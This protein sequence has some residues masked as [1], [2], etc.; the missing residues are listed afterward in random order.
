[1]SESAP[2]DGGG[3]S[4]PPTHATA[5][6][7]EKVRLA[8]FRNI[9]SATLEPSSRLN[10]IW[11]DNGQGKTS[12]LEALYA[13]ATTRS[14]RTDKLAQALRTGDQQ[15]R[16]HASVREDDFERELTLRFA[17]KGRSVELDG[18]R[19][20]TLASY[21]VRTPI[22]VFHPRDLELVTGGALER[23]RL[24][25][26]LILYADPPG[27]EAGRRYAEALKDRQR[28]LE[29][30]GVAAAELGDFENVAAEHGARFARARAEAA[31]RLLPE[32]T[33]AFQSV[34]PADLELSAGY[35]AGGSLNREAFKAEL[36]AR[37]PEDARR[38]RASFGPQRDELELLA[39]GRAARS[40]ASQGQQR[41]LSLSLKL[42][43]LRCIEQAR[44]ARPVLLLD[45]VSSELDRTR[46][47]RF[48]ALL[49]QIGGQVF[50]TT[51]HPELIRLEDGR[52]DWHVE[53]GRVKRA[54]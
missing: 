13:V 37:R 22:V 24:L 27:A 54:P 15:A 20:Q 6:R 41:L 30:R 36:R 10:L 4:A 44:R 48:F 11:G 7:F 23:R 12:V 9:E 34:A 43:E 46:N 19:P 47:E 25:D 8:S 16:V 1:M 50:L 17:A 45:D 26:R 5:L 49:A 28:L 40:D 21:A 42:A 52:S 18:K 33:Q 39:C 3:A 51:T 29:D 31:E 2:P 53:S 14:F 35:L 38:G 32:L